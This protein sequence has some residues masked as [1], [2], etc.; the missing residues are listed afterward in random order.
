[1]EIN[2]L[3]SLFKNFLKDIEELWRA[4]WLWKERK[5]NIWVRK[6]YVATWLL[7]FWW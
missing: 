4:L 6:S 1:M 7:E 3:I 2:E 5:K